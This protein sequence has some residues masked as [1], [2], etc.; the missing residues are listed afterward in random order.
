MQLKHR[1]ISRNSLGTVRQSE[2]FRYGAHGR[3]AATTNVNP[4]RNT[5]RR[6]GGYGQVIVARVDAEGY[7]QIVDRAKALIRSGGESISSV[8]LETALL[9]HPVGA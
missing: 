1:P 8:A 4:Q 6:T 2:K 3:R 9:K 7:M 5:G